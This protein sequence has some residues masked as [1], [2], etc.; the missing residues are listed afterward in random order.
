MPTLHHVTFENHT[1]CVLHRPDGVLLLD[2][3][4][5][6]QLLGY[7][8]DFG[9]LHAHCRTEGFAFGNQP[10]PTIWIDMHNAYRL[11]F[12]SELPM[13]ER[14]AHWLSHWL[15]PHF[16]RRWQPQTL[17]AYIGGQHLRV[18]SWQGECWITYNDALGTLDQNLLKTLAQ[19]VAPP[20]DPITTSAPVEPLWAADATGR[21]SPSEP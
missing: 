16:S 13:A 9:A 21:N 6:A 8:D 14:L 18:L 12:H 20:T 4:P 15:L 7:P 2:G 19:C 17:R 1:L 11:I 5:L 3:P 10:R